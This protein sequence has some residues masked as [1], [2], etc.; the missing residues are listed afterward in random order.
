MENGNSCFHMAMSATG[1]CRIELPG[2][3]LHPVPNGTSRVSG[4]TLRA[5][6]IG[7]VHRSLSD[8]PS[9]GAAMWARAYKPACEADL[10]TRPHGIVESESPQNR[11]ETLA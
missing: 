6:P 9:W 5:L 1:V 3:S 7:T 11:Y 2:G 10:K 4:A 8:T